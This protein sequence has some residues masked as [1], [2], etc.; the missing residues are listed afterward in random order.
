MRQSIAFRVQQRGCLAPRRVIQREDRDQLRI[1]NGL[2]GETIRERHKGHRR[3]VLPRLP[4]AGLGVTRQ[5]IA[6]HGAEHELWDR[7]CVANERHVTAPSAAL[8][9]GGDFG[10]EFVIT[11]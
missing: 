6:I 7:E 5:D 9:I 1:D 10:S 2:A 11:D 8:N 4:R 3:L